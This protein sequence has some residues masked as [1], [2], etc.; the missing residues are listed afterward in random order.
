MARQSFEPRLRATGLSP[1]A[2]PVDTYVR[3]ETG[4]SQL[5]SALSDVAPELRR[6]SDILAKRDAEIESQRGAAKARELMEKGMSYAD[7][8]AAGEIKP[9]SSPF[10]L[11]SLKEQ[12]GRVD[13]DTWEGEFIKDVGQNEGL[14]KAI[15]MEAFDKFAMEH[16]ANFLKKRLGEQG[17]DLAY[18]QGFGARSDQYYFAARQKYAEGL[19]GRVK[20]TSTDLHFAEVKRTTRDILSKGLPA[21]DVATAVENMYV[22]L[23][24]R[25]D[26]PVDFQKATIEAIAAAATEARDEKYLDVLKHIK[27]PGSEETLWDSTDGSET[28]KETRRYIYNEKVM[29]AEAWRAEQKRQ[30]DAK[31][32]GVFQKYIKAQSEK[33]GENIPLR[34]FVEELADADAAKQL[35]QLSEVMLQVNVRTD[36]NTYFQALRDIMEPESGVPLSFN[37]LVNLRVTGELDTPAFEK[38]MKYRQDE[39]ERRSRGG[40]DPVREDPQVQEILNGITAERFA[41]LLSNI[42]GNTTHDKKQNA[43]VML[44]DYAYKNWPTLKDMKPQDRLK[45]LHDFARAGVSEQR[46][47]KEA[48]ASTRAPEPVYAGEIP[49]DLVLTAEEIRWTLH[50]NG[51]IPPSLNRKFLKYD[52]RSTDKAL[53]FGKGQADYYFKKRGIKIEADNTDA[54]GSADTIQNE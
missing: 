43:R 31:I 52:I 18:E 37:D 50:P 34:P 22:S 33:P 24:A 49:K 26:K 10:Y 46:G 39:M 36:D 29:Y 19:A 15:S 3:P 13:A 7:A 17:R 23:S 6:Y 38:L 9:Q 28:I 32:E 16:R 20:K 25:G 45:A 21:E 48:S 2:R 54:T 11:A 8:V 1:T 47:G 27:I 53:E 4:A 5:A 41:G 44:L 35:Q 40:S 42:V 51:D 30:K 14:K 12:S